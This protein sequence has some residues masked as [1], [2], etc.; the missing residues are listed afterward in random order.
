MSLFKLSYATPRLEKYDF[1]TL[2]LAVLYRGMLDED[3][4]LD[5]V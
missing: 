5:D 1:L 4:Y 3:M 2:A